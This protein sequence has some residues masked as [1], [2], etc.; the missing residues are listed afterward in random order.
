MAEESRL[1]VPDPTGRLMFLPAKA[2]PSRKMRE[3]RER[4]RKKTAELRIGRGGVTWCA[5]CAQR[6]LMLDPIGHVVRG[7]TV[8]HNECPAYCG[9]EVPV[10]VVENG[11]TV[12]HRAIP[13]EVKP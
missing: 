12:L 1:F 3:A 7:E 9:S 8:R 11:Q 2:R 6:F 10:Y 5:R 13:Q 4:T